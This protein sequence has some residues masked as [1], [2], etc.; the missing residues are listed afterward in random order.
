MMANIT[1][2]A[3][4][5]LLAALFIVLGGCCTYHGKAVSKAEAA[6]MKAMGMDVRCP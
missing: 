5:A 6:R 3:T 2:K 1:F 4:L